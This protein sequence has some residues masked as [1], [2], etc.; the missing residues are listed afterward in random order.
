MKQYQPS[1]YAELVFKYFGNK[2][3]KIIL[4]IVFILTCIFAIISK[5]IMAILGGIFIIIIF[6]RLLSGAIENKRIEKYCKN[7]N[8]TT[9]EFNTIYKQ[10]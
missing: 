3:I 2:S 4:P 5:L 9:D 1:E 8:I 10:I 6:S 7:N